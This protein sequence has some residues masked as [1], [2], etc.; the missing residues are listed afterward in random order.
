[1]PPPEARASRGVFDSRSAK[2]EGG[3]SVKADKRSSSPTYK[4]VTMAKRV[5]V[6]ALILTA[7][8]VVVAPALAFD[9]YRVD[10]DNATVCQG[11]HDTG[12]IGPAV[13]PKWSNTA[14]AMI[15]NPAAFTANAL[16]ISYG[17]ACAG[18]HS[19]NYDPTKAQ[20]AGTPPY[21]V[22][23]P[24]QNTVLPNDAF[25]EPVAGCSTCHY[26][27]DYAHTTPNTELANP[28]ICGQCHARYSTNKT[29]YALLA[30]IGENL[31]S[32]YAPEY[33]VGYNPFNTAL[34]SVLDIPTPA[35]PQRNAFWLGG[36]S[37]KAHGEGAVQYEEWATGLGN[38]G[39]ISHGNA[40]T[41]IKAFIPAS[42]IDQ[43]K[44]LE[45]HSEDYRM[46]PDNAK[47]TSAEAKYGITC[48]TCHDP[49]EKGAQ[50]SVWNKDRNP[51]LKA[52]RQ[53]LCVECHNAELG[54][55]GIAAAG[56]EVHHPM[57]E[58]MNG[59]GAIDVAQ[60]SP[61]VHKGKCVQCHMVPTGYE[62]DGA[63]GTAGNHVFAIIT[64]DEA[65]TQ[66]TTTA[67]GDQVMPYSSCTTCH[68]RPGDEQA[69]WLQSTLDDRQ[70]AMHE[71]DDQVT[72]ALGAAAV[73]LGFTGA[74]DAAKI[75]N[76][77][78][79]LN[80]KKTA[81]GTWNASQLN[82]QKAFTNQKYIESEG[83][84]GIH[85]W[86]YARSIILTAKS[87]ATAVTAT[88]VITIKASPTS[89]KKNKT[90]KFTGTVATS[91]TGT[92]TVKVKSG[93][94]WKNAGTA[95]LKGTGTYSVSIKMT[96]KGTFYYKAVFPASATQLGGTSAQVKV[97]V[98]K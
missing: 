12:G 31:A 36:Q 53:D 20:G 50:A 62:Y 76:A 74:D 9:G 59:T 84:W 75:A 18:C 29:S 38:P 73:R 51:Q 86:E 30:P 71:W 93:S 96:K 70:A 43:G 87:Q 10:Y 66:T 90:V 46:S 14:H 85:N 17:P 52:P 21:N 44:C 82:F 69:T 42:V 15:G 23:Y 61:S 68:S 45:C 35:S 33:T 77:N 7:M 8:L 47:P 6:L 5:L 92:V 22:T 4:E 27:S 83:S 41:T 60:G 63:A 24:H 56:S 19:G 67:T 2:R 28:A 80:A 3:D 58:M 79:A 25:S 55:G 95:P 91:T 1:M 32:P 54:P 81:G 48:A 49:H 26:N 16:P 78:E 40:L 94:S 98:K 72:V 88:T 89:L 11:C 39:M 64:P 97:V 34:D 57:K 65:A 37:T 13:Y